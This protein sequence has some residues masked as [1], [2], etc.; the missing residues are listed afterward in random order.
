MIPKFFVNILFVFTSFLVVSQDLSYNALTI[1]PDLKKDANAIIRLNDVS[2]VMETASKMYTKGKRV[3]TVFNKRG[4]KHVNAHAYYDETTKIKDL[5]AI[6]YDGFGEPLKKIRESD[7]KD[8]SAVDGGTLYS[9]SRVKYLEYTPASYPYTVEFTYEIVN[10]NT[11]FI[12]SFTPINDY[13]LSV[14]NS[15]YSIA[16]GEEIQLR[17]KENNFNAIELIKEDKPGILKF[18]VKDIPAFEPEAYSPATNVLLPEVMIASDKFVYEGVFADVNNWKS[19]GSW[20]HNN[21][22]KGRSAISTGT[23][24][25]ILKLVDGVDN[26]IERAKIVYQ[27]V[28]DNARYISVQVGI[29]GMQPIS[30]I[31]VDLLKYGDCKG[32]SNYTKSLLEI[33]GVESYYTRLYASRDNVLNVKNDFVSFQGQTNHVI[34]N[35]PDNGNDIWLECTSQDA[36]FGFIGAFTDDRDALVITPEGGQIKHTKKYLPEESLQSISGEYSLTGAGDIKAEVVIKSMGIQ[37]DD[38]YKLDSETPR[39]LDKHYKTRWRYINGLVLHDFKI[40]NNKD[41]VIFSE[42]VVFEASKYA[43]IVGDRMLFSVNAFNRN[44]EIPN[45]YRNRKFPLKINRGFK[46]VDVFTITLPK[47]YKIEALPHDVL[48]ENKFGRYLAEVQKI[49]ETT[50]KYSREFTVLDGQFPKENY[51]KFRDFF[52]TVAKNDNAKIA[53]I[54]TNTNP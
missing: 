27:F 33:A 14:E 7:F 42:N 49:D 54:K 52:K 43:K 47:G 11:A 15:Q 26:P 18:R 24:S 9:D 23:R 48:I 10:E 37:Y 32:L 45:R 6:V 50:I 17:T 39:E 41:D 46:D 51:A 34:L 25:K 8:V 38:K 35:I 29:G 3:V 28:Q 40:V 36:P 31:E 4:N 13:F 1:S 20:F 21:L 12:R 44:R 53:L 5:K 30:A 2:I 19:M 22:L 16:Y